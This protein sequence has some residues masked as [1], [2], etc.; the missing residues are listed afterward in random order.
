MRIPRIIKVL[1]SGSVFLSLA[2]AMAD[3]VP[4]IDQVQE[5]WSLVVASPDLDGVGPQIT[6][7]MSPVS[8]NS[9][10]FV[11]FD[12]NYRE[13]PSFSAGGLQLQ[14]WSNGR[15]PTTCTQETA[16]LATANETITWTQQISLSNNNL[17]YDILGGKSTTWGRFGQGNGNLSISFATTI[18]D[19][20]A[21]SPDYSLAKSGVTWESNHVSSMTLVQV[22]YYSGGQL[23][24]TDTKSRPVNLGN[25]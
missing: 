22:R 5:D 15:V 14:V 24:S 7:C 1:V 4:V 13:F 25:N 17:N 21:Y 16:Q 19:L 20:S 3:P 8:D 23:V 11:A 2:T 9:T 10:P 6:T 18:N 12:M